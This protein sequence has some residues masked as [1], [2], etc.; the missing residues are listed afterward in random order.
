[1]MA[2]KRAFKFERTSYHEFCVCRA[3]HTVDFSADVVADEAVVVDGKVQ[4]SIAAVCGGQTSASVADRDFSRD[5]PVDQPMN[6]QR[7]AQSTLNNVMNEE[8][9]PLSDDPDLQFAVSFLYY[10]FLTSSTQI[11]LLCR[12]ANVDSARD[13]LICVGPDGVHVQAGVIPSG[14]VPT[15]T[16]SCDREILMQIIRGVMACLCFRLAGFS[17]S[18]VRLCIR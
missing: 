14:V 11:R 1:M 6:E 9:A 5:V 3:E 8:L 7:E 15:C 17:I 2:F 12:L 10:A 18:T 13:L 16:V 4:A